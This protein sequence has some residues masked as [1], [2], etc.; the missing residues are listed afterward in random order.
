MKPEAYCSPSR[1]CGRTTRPLRI[2]YLAGPGNVLGAY[3]CLERGEKDTTNSH[4]GYSELMVRA[5]QSVGA[6]ALLALTTNESGGTWRSFPM[7]FDDLTVQVERIPDHFAGKHG[8]RYHAANWTMARHVRKVLERFRADVLVVGDD[9]QRAAA[10]RWMLP[11][12]CKLVRVQHCALTPLLRERSAKERALLAID[13]ALAPRFAAVLTASQQVSEQVR[14]LWPDAPVVEFLPHFDRELHVVERA[15]PSLWE[16][17]DLNA[18][19]PPGWTTCGSVRKR[20]L[21]CV[22]VGRALREKGIFDLLE[23][24]IILREAGAPVRIELCGDGPD[25]AE[26]KR[27]AEEARLGDRFVLHGWCQRQRME[28]VMAGAHIGLAPTRS[29]FGE[30]FCQSAVELCLRRLP[31]IASRAIPAV[32]YLGEAVSIVPHDDAGTLA[33]ELA[34]LA[35]D[36]GFGAVERMHRACGEVTAKFLRHDTSYAA[37]M[38][39]VLGALARGAAV[40]ERLISHDGEVVS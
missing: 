2:A 24:A 8:W 39:H 18:D 4:V 36:K 23:A 5:C 10:L 11:K 26:L 22:F 38:E 13:Q 17:L 34:Y 28:E 31:L 27:Q 12:G 32:R 16:E 25:F 30:G 3:E 19:S 9:P 37:A 15:L 14:E 33:L 20:E 7:R 6:S 21:R 1:A 35:S 29:D 40:R